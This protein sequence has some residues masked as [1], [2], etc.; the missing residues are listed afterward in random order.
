[1]GKGEGVVLCGP[2]WQGVSEGLVT[3][4]RA[5]LEQGR[6]SGRVTWLHQAPTAMG[7]TLVVESTLG[8]TALVWALVSEVDSVCLFIE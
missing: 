4:R 2:C 1:M 6:A 5:A 8:L 3:W 7:A